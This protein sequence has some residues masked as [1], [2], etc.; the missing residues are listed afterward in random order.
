MRAL[1]IFFTSATGTRVP[2]S[3]RTVPVEVSYFFPEI[4]ILTYPWK[5]K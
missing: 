4:E 2:G 5:K 1:T 3:K